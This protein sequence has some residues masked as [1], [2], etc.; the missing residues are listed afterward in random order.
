[1]HRLKGSRPT[2]AVAG[3][4]AACAL[5]VTAC[6]SSNSSSSDSSS[7]SSSG[8]SSSTPAS[9]SSSGKL[10]TSKPYRVL[11]LVDTT[12][13][14]KALGGQDLLGIQAAA[15]YWN[16]NGGIDGRKV[17]VTSVSTN[18]D[19]TTA[20]TQFTKWVASNGKPDLVAPPGTSGV[21]TTGMVP[22]LQRADVL[23]IGF[24]WDPCSSNAQKTCPTRFTFSVGE[25]WPAVAAAN[26][27]KSKGVKKVGILAEE[28]S[29]SESEIAP[30][31][32]QLAKQ[33]IQT[34]SAT[35]PQTAVNVVA[36][37]SKL[38]SAGADAIYGAALGPSTAYIADARS[39]LGMVDSTPLLWDPGASALDITKLASAAELKNSWENTQ[40]PAVP[41]LK[42]PGRDLL[43]KYMKPLGPI[44][45]PLYIHSYMWDALLLVHDA[46]E[47][48]GGKTDTASM[49]STFQNLDPKY[50][51]DPLWMTNPA[52]QFTTDSHTNT[53]G[54]AQSNVVVP[55]G[56]LVNGQVQPPK[57]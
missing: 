36:E 29:F 1:M 27:Y 22:A 15:A 47:Q 28:D 3:I 39:K 2:L 25:T 48:N 30:L 20:V 24:S 45:Q 13:P 18:G 14:T 42:M 7:S 17:T 38:K 56:P 40:R 53:L 4:A 16:A 12:G 33:G 46:L 6:G 34:V 9:G 57:S 11:A 55:T 52:V 51:H 19:P 49:V 31:K 43:L 44:E 50:I 41:T 35:F 26:W 37:M 32:Q 54:N 5:A 23:G 21:D 8:S 10:D